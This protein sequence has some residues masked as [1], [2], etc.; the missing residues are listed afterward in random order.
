MLIKK[1]YSAVLVCEFFGKEGWTLH[2]ILVIT[3][4]NDNSNELI[5][6]AFDH[7]SDDGKQDAW[8]DV[9]KG[10]GTGICKIHLY[11]VL[12]KFE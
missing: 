7:W 9:R 11:P 2:T 1:K 6:R 8:W 12:S 3:K 5:I 10:Q 4:S